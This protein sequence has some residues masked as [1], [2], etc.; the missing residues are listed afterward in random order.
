MAGTALTD[1]ATGYVAKK[2]APDAFRDT[3]VNTGIKL[4]GSSMM[5]LGLV[6]AVG[7]AGGLLASLPTL[8]AHTKEQKNQ[9]KSN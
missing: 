9:R 1:F 5:H 2:L 4:L 7:V 3:A 6:M 8:I